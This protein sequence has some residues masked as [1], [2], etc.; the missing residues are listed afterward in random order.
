MRLCNFVREVDS[1]PSYAEPYGHTRSGWRSLGHGTPLAS[2]AATHSAP[3]TP[4]AFFINWLFQ[5]AI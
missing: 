3:N 4:A 1:T 2:S 5:S